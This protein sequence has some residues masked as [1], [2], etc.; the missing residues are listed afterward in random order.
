MSVLKPTMSITRFAVSE[1]DEV[2]D[3]IMD[4]MLQN[5][6]GNRIVDLEIG[7]EIAWGWTKLS[8]PFCPYFDDM[9]FMVSNYVTLGFRIDKKSVPAAVI[10]K[11]VYLAEK[12]FK[13]ENQLPKIARAQ[14][15]MIKEAIVKNLLN[16]APAVP[17]TY[18]VVWCIDT[19][20]LYL[21]TTNKLAKDLLEEV[22]QDTFGLT[23]TMTF[24]FTMGL[25][26]VDEATLSRIQPTSFV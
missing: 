9:S 13:Q 4:E 3:N 6:K 7:E 12:K 5:I 20:E 8:D 25:N 22:M 21:F 24:P 16:S 23:V 18:D 19:H 1:P 2:S 10:N 17:A 26:D 15:I 11:E 14:K